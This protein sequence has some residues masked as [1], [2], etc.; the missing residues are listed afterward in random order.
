VLVGVKVGASLTGLAGATRGV[1]ATGLACVG[2]VAEVEA[3]CA[4]NM[5]NTAKQ[6]TMT[7]AHA[8][9]ARRIAEP[10]TLHCYR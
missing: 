6:T 5:P 4:S 2:A 7:S 3:F 1:D 10:P 8:A 9:A